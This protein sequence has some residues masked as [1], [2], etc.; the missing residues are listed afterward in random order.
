M[1]EGTDEETTQRLARAEE[2]AAREA[3]ELAAGDGAEA[4]DGNKGD[5]EPPRKRGTA[6]GADNGKRP[7]RTEAENIRSAKTGTIEVHRG[8]V[9]RADAQDVS[10]SVG[11]VG[12]AR[13]DRVS[14]EL[15]GIGA[16]IAGEV[17]I[18]Q[19]AANAVIAREVE[20]EQAFVQSVV[21]ARVEV[22]EGSNVLFLVAGRVDGPVRPVFDWRG[23]LAFGA[24][25]GLV[26]A[27]LRLL[28]R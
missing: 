3:A 7:S 18:R 27:L 14:V 24:A 5:R 20:L 8:G 15:G 1:A 13:A 11:G 16:A 4:G 6:S 26:M 12:L 28:R 25:A 22:A 21:A 9:G 19:G 17:E 23:A 10:V 2:A